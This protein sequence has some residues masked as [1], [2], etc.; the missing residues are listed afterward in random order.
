MCLVIG[1][2]YLT[3]YYQNCGGLRTK[4]SQLRLNIL[5]TNYDIIVLTETWFK[6]GIYDSE[7]VD[8]RYCVFRRDR[9]SITSCKKDGGGIIVAIKKTLPATRRADLECSRVEEIIITLP[10]TNSTSF[11]LCAVYIPP[12]SSKSTYESHFRSLNDLYTGSPCNDFCIVGDYNLPD[13][14]WPSQPSNSF[15]TLSGHINGTH[16]GLTDVM[17]YLQLYQFN[18][19]KNQKGRILDLF[20]SPNQEWVCSEP[21]T[22]L[23]RRHGHHPPLLFTLANSRLKKSIP[24]ASNVRPNFNKCNYNEIE[25]VLQTIDW[26]KEFELKNASESVNYFYEVIY[27][28]IDKNVPNKKAKSSHYPKWFSNPLIKTLTKKQKVWKRWKV[29][30]NLSDY[31][32]F[33]LLRARAKKLLSDSLQS[34]IVNTES[35]LSKNINEFWKYVSSLKKNDSSYPNSMYLNDKTADKPEE[36]AELFNS[37]FGSVYEPATTLTELELQCLPSGEIFPTISSL[38][39][40]RDKIELSLKNLNP[41]K[42]PGPDNLPSAFLKQLHKCLSEPLY[43]I[44][45]KCLSEGVLPDQWKNALVTPIFKSGSRPNVS[46]YRPISV[47]SHIPKIFESLVHRSISQALTPY[48]NYQQHGFTA[49]R[50]TVTNLLIYTDYI[51][52]S[53]DK[54]VQVDAIYT[55]FQKAFDKVDHELLLKKLAYSGIGGSLLRWFASYLKNRY[56]IININGH[57]SQRKLVS[58]GVIQGS[59]LGPLQYTIFINDI[60]QCFKH[61]RILLFADDLKIFCPVE[62][63][64]DC[65]M[66]QQ[67]LN[68]FNA[69]CK[70]NKL[71]LAHSKCKQISFTRNRNKIIFNYQIDGTQL[72]RVSSIRDLGITLDEKF[73]LDQHIDAICTKAYQMLG[74]VLRVTKQ[75]KKP[76][77]FILLYESL[78]RSHLEYASAIWNPLYATYS[79]KL[80]S[81]Q[82]KAL[83]AIHYRISHS[84][85]SYHNLL[86]HYN[87]QSLSSR[88]LYHD[89]MVLYN[90]CRSNFN[91]PSLLEQI[92]FRVPKSLSSRRRC[93]DLFYIPPTK[94]NAGVRAPIHRITKAHNEKFSTLDIFNANKYKFKKEIRH[95][96]EINN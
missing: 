88:R 16:K 71:Q 27:D 59:I 85:M 49:G 73:T 51:F 48:I 24:A 81:I 39:I 42:G 74:F 37:F 91:C 53:L 41:N 32:E 34:F 94:T 20:L 86:N 75:F 96:I 8:D 67:D 21:S 62:S 22:T 95:L 80:E 83:K 93:T 7:I 44:F 66:V 52:Q 14:Q 33:S 55:D 77:T 87:L 36:I 1:S 40:P 64:S 79:E 6:P 69:Y 15:S 90:I 70:E 45:N 3:I 57:R 76:S 13:L 60:S 72:D 17:A 12:S 82:K 63:T 23:S 84:K 11:C 25:T 65:E 18:T 31:R 2:T 46:D 47:L 26:L 28:L 30:K 19:F 38:Q 43:I 68:R 61:C 92:N 29:Y 4:L 10:L 56:Q 58:S 9:S 78:V 50:S 89:E 35:N 54:Q 5:N